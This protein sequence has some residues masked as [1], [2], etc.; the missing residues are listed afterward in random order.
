MFVG[1]PG[2]AQVMRLQTYTAH[3]VSVLRAGRLHCLRG[4]DQVALH[5]SPDAAMSALR[6]LQQRVVLVRGA[7]R[8]EFP[9]FRVMQSFEILDLKGQTATRAPPDLDKCVRRLS[10]V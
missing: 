3:L 10:K 8:S 2:Q 9:H 5:Y 4:E 7:A 6:K 1:N